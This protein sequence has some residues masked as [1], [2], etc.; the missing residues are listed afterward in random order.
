MT[1]NLFANLQRTKELSIRICSVLNFFLQLLKE[2]WFNLNFKYIFFNF[3]RRQWTKKEYSIAP[4]LPGLHS[5]NIKVL[6]KQW[7][8][9]NLYCPPSRKDRH[10]PHC[11]IMDLNSRICQ[12][13]DCITCGTSVPL[14]LLPFHIE[15]CQCDDNVSDL[16]QLFC[17][18]SKTALF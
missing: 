2:H 4:G 1:P 10:G 9:H 5:Q 13:N 7:K 14:Q 8:K 16:I 18:N 17:R 12:K 6:L 11:H 3:Q 15:S